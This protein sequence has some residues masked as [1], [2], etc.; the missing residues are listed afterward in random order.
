MGQK[1]SVIRFRYTVGMSQ[2]FFGDTLSFQQMMS[3]NLGS[4]VQLA[5]FYEH[6]VIGFSTLSNS[7]TFGV[8]FLW[9]NPAMLRP[10]GAANSGAVTV[11]NTTPAGFTGI[12]ASTGLFTWVKPSTLGVA[13][14]TQLT[15]IGTVGGDY[16]V[17]P[18]IVEVQRT[19]GVSSSGSMIIAG[20]LMNPIHP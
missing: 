16:F 5:P 12:G 20:Y 17:T 7:G 15:F 1:A 10:Y 19:G 18:D 8:R 11:L 13:G 3:T 4:G 14:T 9:A 6:A 2:Q